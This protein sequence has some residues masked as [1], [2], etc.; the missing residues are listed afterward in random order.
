MIKDSAKKRGEYYHAV[1]TVTDS[2]YKK[3][4]YS[5]DVFVNRATALKQAAW[6]KYE[7]EQIGQ[8]IDY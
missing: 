5:K 4:Y 3:T 2:D 6:W 7:T 8:V 1:L